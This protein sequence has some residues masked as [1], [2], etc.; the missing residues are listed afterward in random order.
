M[1]GFETQLAERIELFQSLPDEDLFKI[2]ESELQGST[3]GPEGKPSPVER[4]RFEVEQV[5]DAAQRQICGSEQIQAALTGEASPTIG[6]GVLIGTAA[7]DYVTADY[8]LVSF[9]A[10]VAVVL[11]RRGLRGF[12]E[13]VTLDE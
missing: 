7:L 5:I 2:L 3:L 8:P 6:E 13:G 9:S 10:V 4:A 11:L 12:C 1:S